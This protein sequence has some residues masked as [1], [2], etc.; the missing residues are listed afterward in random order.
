MN[1]E[2]LNGLFTAL[3]AAIDQAAVSVS[4]TLLNPEAEIVVTYPPGG[5]L[6]AEEISALKQMTLS[7][8]ARSALEKLIKDACAS[9]IFELLCLTDGVADVITSNDEPW[10]GLSLEPRKSED[11]QMLHDFFYESYWLF[12]NRSEQ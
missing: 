2:I 4:E 5:T 9:P 12:H 6:T 7:P 11:Q 8:A 10:L 1:E 3:H